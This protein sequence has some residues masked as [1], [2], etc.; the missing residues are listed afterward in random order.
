M[1]EVYV[2][3]FMSLVILGSWEQLRHVAAVFPP[4]AD[5]SY[6]PISEKKLRAQE[7]LYSM[8]ETLL[9]FDF[10]GTAKTMWPKAAKQEKLLTIL[11]GWIQTGQQGMA[12]IQFAKFKSTV[13]KL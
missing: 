1:V 3:E 5:D 8:R 13:A 2:N 11:K 9:G 6:D 12:G 7:G 4:N 10:D